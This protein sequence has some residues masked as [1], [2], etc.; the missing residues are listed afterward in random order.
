MKS[1]TVIRTVAAGAAA[2]AIALT[3]GSC[4]MQHSVAKYEQATSREVAGMGVVQV[5]TI[6]DL[7]VEATRMTYE[8]EQSILSKKMK[9]LRKHLFNFGKLAQ[10]NQLENQLEENAYRT[11]RAMQQIAKSQMLITYGADVLIDPRYSIEIVDNDKI[12]VIVSGYLGKYK[13][14]RPIQPKDTA[15]FQIEPTIYRPDYN[16]NGITIKK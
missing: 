11:A 1:T 9:K 2:S 3:I 8:Y 4:K 13:N 5:P 6:V 16:M 15:L 12:K 7:D 10:S 14:F